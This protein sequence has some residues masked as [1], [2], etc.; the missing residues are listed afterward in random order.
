MEEKFEF[1]LG[2]QC[3][4]EGLSNLRDNSVCSTIVVVVVMNIV[5]K[6]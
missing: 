3:F 5:V 1:I 2:L 6:L 4:G